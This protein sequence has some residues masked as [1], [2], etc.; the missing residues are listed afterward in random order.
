MAPETRP[1]VPNTADTRR[2]TAADSNCERA[3]DKMSS[4]D[5]RVRRKPAGEN[6][7]VLSEHSGSA[8]T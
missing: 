3:K 6:L 4:R 8:L 7:L 1:F 5:R 2:L